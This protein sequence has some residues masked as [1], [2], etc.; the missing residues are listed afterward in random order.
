MITG[1][2]FAAL[3]VVWGLAQV[4]KHWRGR[5]AHGAASEGSPPR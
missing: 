4:I 5:A 3:A 1:L 2:T